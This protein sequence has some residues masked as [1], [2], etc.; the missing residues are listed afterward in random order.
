[1]E[2]GIFDSRKDE[3]NVGGIRGLREAVGSSIRLRYHT[4][5]ALRALTG[6]RG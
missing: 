1:M 6:D 2:D 4:R 3:A 5:T